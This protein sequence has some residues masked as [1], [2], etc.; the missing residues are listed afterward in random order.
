M[1]RR[2]IKRIALFG[3]LAVVLAGA[4]LGLSL[5]LALKQLTP[6]NIILQLES[7]YNCRA[8]LDACT[9]SLFSSPAKIELYGVQLSPR[10]TEADNATLPSTRSPAVMRATYLKMGRAVLE[11]DLAALVWKRELKVKQFVIERADVKCDLLSG[12]ENTLRTLFATPEVVK[13]RPNPAL[14]ALAPVAAAAH[15][16]TQGGK[17]A[18]PPAPSEFNDEPR[19]VFH[20]SELKIPSSLERVALVDSRLRFRNRKSRSVIELSGCTLELSD[21][22]VDPANLAAANHATLSLKTKLLLDSRK[23]ENLR[24][25]DLGAAIEGKIIPFDPAT[26]FLNPDFTFDMTLAEGSVVQSLPLMQKL[27]RNLDKARQAGLKMKNL[28]APQALA[29]DTTLKFQLRSNRLTLLEDN[30]LDFPDYALSMQQGGY[31]DAGTETHEFHASL[32]ASEAVS[33]AALKEADEFLSSLGDSAGEE[34]R[35][36]FITPLVRD[37]RIAMTFVTSGDTDDPKVK[38]DHPLQDL[39]DQLKDAGRDLID[40]LRNK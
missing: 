14:L 16:A 35:R 19:R 25:A 28:A 11:A 20:A 1:S 26:G 31:L 38:I 29:H 12:G 34:L 10:D 7:A 22:A 3:G 6:D 9:V 33:T 27:Q 5:W 2:L 36:F 8:K 18:E 37:G 23:K 40:R 24:Y 39:Q 21:L 32:I 15:I 13:G 17:A 30:S 4:A